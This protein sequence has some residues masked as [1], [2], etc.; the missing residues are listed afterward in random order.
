[1]MFLLLFSCAYLVF[2]SIN[3]AI[4]T[5]MNRKESSEEYGSSLILVSWGPVLILTILCV[6]ISDSGVVSKIDAFLSSLFLKKS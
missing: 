2:I 3:F 1:M 4:T 6:A 5:Y